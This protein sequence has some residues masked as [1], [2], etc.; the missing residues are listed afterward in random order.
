MFLERAVAW[1]TRGNLIRVALYTVFSIL[2][3]ID[4]CMELRL[5]VNTIENGWQV[6]YFSILWKKRRNYFLSHCVVRLALLLRE[7]E[8]GDQE[9]AKTPT[10]PHRTKEKQFFKS[11]V[12]FCYSCWLGVI[13]ELSFSQGSPV[14]LPPQKSTFLNSNSI[15]DEG[16]KFISL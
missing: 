5:L 1:L 15:M 14:F 7:R 11:Q 12:Q 3:L 10:K 13:C 2:M 8:R 16:H 6:F 9:M 4:L